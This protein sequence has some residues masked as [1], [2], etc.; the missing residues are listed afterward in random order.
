[1][2]AIFLGVGSNIDREKQL[3]QGLDALAALLG[4][5]S[6]SSVYDSE[7]VGFTG[8]PYLNMVVGAE[9]SL[10]VADLSERLRGIE[11]EFGRAPSAPSNSSRKLDIDLLTY[12]QHVGRVGRVELPRAEIL[13]N[14]FVLCPLS[15]LAPRE[16]HPQV[17][18]S[19]AELWAEFDKS[20]QPLTAVDFHWR[21]RQISRGA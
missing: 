16:L 10:A 14:A 12:D 21:D 18:R 9:T 3:A 11:F 6:L 8:P 20:S 19:Y 4:E 2:A 1:M 15:E 17:K 13:Y 7:A 5:L